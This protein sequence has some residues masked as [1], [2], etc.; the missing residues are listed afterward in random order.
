MTFFLFFHWVSWNEILLDQIMMMSLI[1]INS[2]LWVHD[3]FV[4]RR[5]PVAKL[6]HGRLIRLLDRDVQPLPLYYYKLLL[7]VNLRRAVL[8]IQMDM[9]ILCLSIET[10]QL[11]Y[12]YRYIQLS[13]N[14]AFTTWAYNIQA[15]QIT[16]AY[17][18]FAKSCILS[19]SS[20][21]LFTSFFLFFLNQ[22]KQRFVV[23]VAFSSL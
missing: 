17:K 15:N 13:G 2:K 8:H 14:F 16:C 11:L 5:I 9:Y 7:M 10:L 21:F 3:V 19:P 18:S 23:V 1:W 6:H 4:R 22:E 12:I 20:H